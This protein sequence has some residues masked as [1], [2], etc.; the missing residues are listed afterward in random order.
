MVAA[1]PELHN[2]RLLAFGPDGADDDREAQE[3]GQ[4]MADPMSQTPPGG[5]V[6]TMAEAAR[7]KGVSYHTVS[8]AVRRGKLP[9]QRLGRMALIAAEDLRDWQPMRERA[10]HKYRRREPNPEAAPA[11]L[12]L[13][14]GE[15]VDLANRLST[16]Y[17]IVHAAAAEMPLP[18]FL[19]LLADRFASAMGLRRVSVW[20]FDA[21][22]RRAARLASFGPPFSMLP[23]EVALGGPAGM[24]RVI[25]AGEATVV[26]DVPENLGVSADD[27]LNV[28]QLVLVP[29]RVGSRQIGVIVGDNNGGQFS[30]RQDQQVLAH[31]LAN[32]AALAIERAELLAEA[33]GGDER[34]AALIEQLPVAVVAADLDGKALLVNAAARELLGLS[35]EDVGD[36]GGASSVS[37]LRNVAGTG[38]VVT[39]TRPDGSD[40]AVTVDARQATGTG[41]EDLTLF[42]LRSADASGIGIDSRASEP[43]QR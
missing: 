23:S 34:W 1:E 22:T 6:Y 4:D 14:S 39:P 30:L 29:L 35:T 40:V 2:L 27:L 19:S 11:L 25:A 8:R 37:A 18:E 20:G 5:D 10:P 36:G 32:Q 7:L 33:R 28:N 41:G 13:A 12:D 21:A 42:V 15:R 16:L 24:E 26:T 17:E 9:A 3:G 38:N 31:S 43:A